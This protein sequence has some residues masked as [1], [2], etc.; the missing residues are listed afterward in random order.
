MKSKPRERPEA[1]KTRTRPARKPRRGDSALR[2][3]LADARRAPQKLVT[4]FRVD[5][6][7][8]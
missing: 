3:V 7:G 5:A 6:Q 8:E 2:A 1:T 4:R